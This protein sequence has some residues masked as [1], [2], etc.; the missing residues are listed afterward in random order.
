VP[1]WLCRVRERIR[2]ERGR[3]ARVAE[4]A[5]DAGVHPVY[6][7]RRFRHAFGSSVVACIQAERLRVAADAL[8]RTGEPLSRV[9]YDAGFADQSHLTRTF[10]RTVGLTPR[11]YRGLAMGR[12]EVANV[13]ER[14]PPGG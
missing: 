5:R 4:L 1:E 7:T 3:G 14:T 9:A 8:A 13:Q 10:S 12:S 6:L 11:V 2:D